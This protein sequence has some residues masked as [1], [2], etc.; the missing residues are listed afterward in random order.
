M[1]PEVDRY[2]GVVLRQIVLALGVE[3]RLGVVNLTGRADSFC[4]NDAAF[5]IKHCSKRLPPWR[6]TYLEENVRELAA[7][8]VKF[9]PVWALLVCGIDGVVGLSFE[10][11]LSVTRSGSTG[12][13]W[14]RVSRSRNSMYRVGGAGGDLPR[15]KPRGV[16]PFIASVMEIE[17]ARRERT[18]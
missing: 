1:I 6:F 2:H 16:G 14:I 17:T 13:A 9:S 12:A 7:L 11:L 4:L 5:Q 3:V 15:A 18:G 10:E 8:R